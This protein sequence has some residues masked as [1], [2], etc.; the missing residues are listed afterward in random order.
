MTI[1]VHRSSVKTIEEGTSTSFQITLESFN[2]I[3]EESPFELCGVFQLS[4][5]A[6]IDLHSNITELLL[7]LDKRKDEVSDKVGGRKEQAST[8]D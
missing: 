1:A 6:T 7:K 8:P 2:G 3:D 4:I 5:S